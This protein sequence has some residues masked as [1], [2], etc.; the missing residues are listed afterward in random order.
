MNGE[1]GVLARV[2]RKEGKPQSETE[3]PEFVVSKVQPSRRA[4]HQWLMGMEKW[5]MEIRS[6]G[7]AEEGAGGLLTEA[8]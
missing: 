7:S 5:L 4:D 2:S 8:Q 1:L 6:E 3:M